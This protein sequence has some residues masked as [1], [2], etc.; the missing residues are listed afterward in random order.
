MDRQTDIEW[1]SK[2]SKLMNHKLGKIV[3]EVKT[4]RDTLN[5]YLHLSH[6]NKQESE[7]WTIT[8][9]K[10]KNGKGKNIKTLF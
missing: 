5:I 2:W 3:F 4:V 10:I 7:I 1:K 8:V 9:S 6:I